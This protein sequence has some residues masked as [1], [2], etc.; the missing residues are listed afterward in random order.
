MYYRGDILRR[1]GFSNEHGFHRHRH[2]RF[3]K[4]DVRLK[5]AGQVASKEF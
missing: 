1:S 2:R 3:A 4:L 5:N